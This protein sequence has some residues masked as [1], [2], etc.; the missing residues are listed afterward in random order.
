M[1]QASSS[2]GIFEKRSLKIARWG[3]VVMAIAG[4]LTAWLANADAL[5]VDGLYSGVNFLASLVAARVGESVM[6]PWD[7]TRPFGYYADEAIYIT[8]RSVILLGILAFAVFSAVTK[9]VAYFSGHEISELVF[10]LIVIY[11]GL[12]VVICL[13]LYFVHRYY[14]LKMG[15]TSDILKTEQQTALIDGV[16]SAGVGLAFGLA[17]LLQNTP[18]Q[19]LLPIIDS[20]IL[21]VLVALIINQPIQSFL[22][23]L[24]EISGQS[25]SPRV[26][27]NIREAVSEAMPDTMDYTLMDVAASKLG[28]FHVVIIYLNC[29]NP[30]RGELVDKL[31]LGIK[32]ACEKRVGLVEVEVVLTATPRLL[33][34]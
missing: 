21:L 4:I 2:L 5:L 30:I 28:R 29:R 22:K 16:I 33:A 26:I 10:G 20:I 23:A 25:S 17:P 7:K 9:I 32:A 19:F 11:S 12:M 6:R 3:N 1:V 14:W 13:G 15:K 31:R 24:A 8:F 34:R 27:E 18:L